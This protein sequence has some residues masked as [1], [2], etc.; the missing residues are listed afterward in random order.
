M[1]PHVVRVRQAEVFVEAV[2]HRKKL[3]MM[4]EMPFAGHARGIALLLEQLG[5]RHFASR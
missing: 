5:D 1:R 2:V 3:L 4:S